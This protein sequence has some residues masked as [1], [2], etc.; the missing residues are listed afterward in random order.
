LFGF[1]FRA[2]VAKFLMEGDCALAELEDQ[3]EV[4]VVGRLFGS[5]PALNAEEGDTGEEVVDL[6]R[7]GESAGGC[8]EFGGGERFGLGL[9][10]GAERGIGGGGA[11][12]TAGER[13]VSAAWERIERSRCGIAFHFGHR[14]EEI[15]EKKGKEMSGIRK[16]KEWGSD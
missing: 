8:G 1:V 7:R 6:F 13:G 14:M 2:L 4:G 10:S 16:M 12:A 3:A 5:K 15:G 9:V 11:A